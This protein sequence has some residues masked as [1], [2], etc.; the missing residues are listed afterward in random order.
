M[1]ALDAATG[2]TLWSFK[3]PGSVNAAP[4]VVNGTLYW[5]TGYHNF[6]PQNP[7]GTSSNRFYAFALPPGNP[8]IKPQTAH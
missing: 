2:A 8:K 5:G 1:Y 7:V 4:A 6:L 3:A